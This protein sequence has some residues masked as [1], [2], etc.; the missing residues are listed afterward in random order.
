MPN[1]TSTAR[2][3]WFTRNSYPPYDH[4]QERRYH[5]VQYLVPR[6]KR[7]RLLDLGCGDGVTSLL[8]SQVTSAVT[9]YELWDL[10]PLF[11][12]NLSTRWLGP[13]ELRVR[14]RDLLTCQSGFHQYTT[15]LLGVL[16]YIFEDKDVVRLLRRIRGFQTFVRVPCAD[17]KRVVINK[18]SRLLEGQYAACYRTVGEMLQL[19]E[20]AGKKVVEV[21]RIWPD[22]IE[23]RFGTHQWMFHLERNFA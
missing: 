20:K 4:V 3:F 10:N 11:L 14:Q 8:L 1:D 19:I 23:S 9:L 5:D 16:P 6:L 15:L 7:E 18:Y 22:N 13:A 12:S 17:H 2:D 21:D